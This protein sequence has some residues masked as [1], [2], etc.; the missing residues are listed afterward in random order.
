MPIYLFLGYQMLELSILLI[1]L[2]III[3]EKN[4][5]KKYK[6]KKKHPK[7]ENLE[8]DI[9]TFSNQKSASKLNSQTGSCRLSHTLILYIK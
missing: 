5:K 1:Q 7:K 4:K 3:Y 6:L 2:A 8:I 9:K